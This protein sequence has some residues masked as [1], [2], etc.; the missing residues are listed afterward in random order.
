MI[1]SQRQIRFRRLQPRTF[2]N[3]QRR[4]DATIGQHPQPKKYLQHPAK[5]QSHR[6]T[7]SLKV[8]STAISPR[9]PTGSADRNK[10]L[11]GLER[12]SGNRAIPTPYPL[13]IR[14]RFKSSQSARK[15]SIL[16]LGDHQASTRFASILLG[17]GDPAMDLFATICAMKRPGI[18]NLPKRPTTHLARKNGSPWQPSARRRPPTSKTATRADKKF[19]LFNHARSLI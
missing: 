8:K 10:L 15:R 6:A 3:Q 14:Q 11:R 1:E 12:K 2:G 5:A 18:A 17:K 4:P 16:P 7:H 9:S 13:S 19:R